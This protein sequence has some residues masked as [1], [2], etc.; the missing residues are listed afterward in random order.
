MKRYAWLAAVICL[1]FVCLVAWRDKD[2]PESSA[3][4]VDRKGQIS[5]LFVE[6]FAEDYYS[7]REL[8]EMA[9]KEAAEY[10]AMTPDKK[11]AVRVDKVE[12]LPAGSSKIM[13]SY[14]YDGWESYTDFNGQK[15]FYGTLGEAARTGFSMD[16]MLKSAADGSLW[17]GKRLSLPADISVIFT[18]VKA[19]IYCPGEVTYISGGASVN[20]DG[21]VDT[22]GAGGTVCILMK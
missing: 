1:C 4:F 20:A 5:A 7:L 2:V 19:N 11:A 15:L 10:N 21:S 17:E 12:M 13:V 14:R 6:D 9:K 3:V 8:A 16:E 22:S 18:D